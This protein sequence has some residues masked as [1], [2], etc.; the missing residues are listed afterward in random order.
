MSWVMF[1]SRIERHT[2]LGA[3]RSDAER[4]CICK[5]GCVVKVSVSKTLENGKYSPRVSFLCVSRGYERY[6]DEQIGPCY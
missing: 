2:R 3:I 4:T 1:V 5:G 6:Y